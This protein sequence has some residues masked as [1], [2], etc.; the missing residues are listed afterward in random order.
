MNGTEI[1]N[2]SKIIWK[3]FR[4]FF[5][6][7]LCIIVA[8]KQKKETVLAK[9][10]DD[11]LY[12]SAAKGIVSPNSSSADSLRMLNNY[13][14]DWVRQKLF[15]NEA[16]R[17]ISNADYIEKQ[18]RDYRS[19]LINYAYQGLIIKEQMDSIVSEDSILQ[20]YERNKESFVLKKALM[21]CDFIKISKKNLQKAN[22]QKYWKDSPTFYDNVLEE[23]N[24]YAQLYIIN[25]SSYLNAD[26]IIMQLPKEAQHEISSKIKKSIEAEDGMYKYFLY[27]KTYLPAGKIAPFSYS[28]NNIKQLYLS[29]RRKEIIE[30]AKD[31]IFEKESRKNNFSI[32]TTRSQK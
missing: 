28:K 10:Y 12:L 17:R 31:N 20:F 5:F 4:Y 15:E 6:I 16:K 21:N 30:K 22:I 3:L 23:C 18:V 19:S 29:K 26:E 24:K 2:S 9:V 14:D 25:D 32:Y 1:E 13:V 8:C 11:Y 27:I 7:I